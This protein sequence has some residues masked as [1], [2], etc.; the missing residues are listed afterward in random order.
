MAEAEGIIEIIGIITTGAE[1]I[2]KIKEVA[3]MLIPSAPKELEDK[4]RWLQCSLKNETQFTVLYQAT[5][6]NSGR[7]WDAPHSFDPFNQLVF[8]CCNDDFAPTGVTGG[9]TFR[10]SLDDQH[11]YDFSLG[12]TNPSLGSYKAAV[13]ESSNPKDAYDAATEEGGHIQ[14]TSIFQGKDKDGQPA[15]FRIHISASASQKPPF[16]VKQVPVA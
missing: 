5:Y 3:D 2:K 8:S 4:F 12:W 16:V 13:V 14:S 7:Y 15:K 9:T 10:L 1:L 11:Y 6:F